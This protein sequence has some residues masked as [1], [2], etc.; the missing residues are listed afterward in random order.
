M[1]IQIEWN[2]F[3]DI[4][5]RVIRAINHA[6]NLQAQDLW[7]TPHSDMADLQEVGS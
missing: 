6:S 4:A 5:P 3:K 2:D 7:R 1:S